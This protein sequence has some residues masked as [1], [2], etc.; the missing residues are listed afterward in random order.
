MED[1]KSV[2]QYLAGIPYIHHGGCGI[3][4]YAMYLWLK[5]HGELSNFKFVL[6]YDEYQISTVENNLNALRDP[7]AIVPDVCNHVLIYNDERYFDAEDDYINLARYDFIQHTR[8][9]WFVVNM[10]NNKGRWN[11]LFDRAYIPKIEEALGIKFEL[12]QP[13]PAKKSFWGLLS[14]PI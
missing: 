4:A 7:G 1:F 11:S 13:K 5:D 2:R 12:D 9:S 10:I 14:H 8:A 6:C 3:A